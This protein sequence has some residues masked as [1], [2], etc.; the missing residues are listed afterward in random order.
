VALNTA[1][2][3]A[4]SGV[5]TVTS[6][7]QGAANALFTMPIN[8]EVVSPFLTADF[9]EDGTVDGDD[10]AT[11]T[12]NLGL[13]GVAEK[14]DGD[15]DSDGDVDGADF[16]TWQRQVGTTPAIAAAASV[17]EPAGAWLTFCAGAA[18]WRWRRSFNPRSATGG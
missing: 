11:W 16:L 9:D 15:A 17:P 3:G 6:S 18:V 8:F 1:T 13:A 7:S 2:L 4:K 5:I 10:L 12:S 14:D